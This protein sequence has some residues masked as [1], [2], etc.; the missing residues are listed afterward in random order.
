MTHETDIE[1]ALVA[2]GTFS[3]LMTG[4]IY[5]VEEIGRNGLSSSQ[6]PGAYDATTLLLKPTCLVKQRSRVPTSD[7]RDEGA[8]TTSYGAVVEIWFYTSADND[9]TVLVTARDR[10]IVV[11]HNSR[12]TGAKVEWIGGTISDKDEGLD[13]A[14]MQRTDFI[15]HAVLT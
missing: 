11:L 14:H 7:I 2:D 3:T 4:G 12:V 8:Q 1:A 9:P 6:T 10:A 5:T 13:N 15:V